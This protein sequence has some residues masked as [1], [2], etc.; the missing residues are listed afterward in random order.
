MKL[1]YL[2][3]CPIDLGNQHPVAVSLTTK[4][5][6]NAINKLT[7]IDNQPID[8]VKKAFGVCCRFVHVEDRNMTMRFIEWVELLKILG[9]NQITLFKHQVY[10]D[11]L[12]VLNHY[13]GKGSIE[14]F[15]YL[16]PSA[17]FTLEGDIKNRQKEVLETLFLTD[18]FYKTKN[19]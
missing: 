13:R 7:I 15:D 11:F 17:F 1:P 2:I 18:C 14:Y 9:V 5:C 12:N 8:G 6:E 19:L 16:E 10:E 3:T 4:P